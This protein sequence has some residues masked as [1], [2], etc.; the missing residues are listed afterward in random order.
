MGDYGQDLVLVWCQWI[1]LGL[2][3]GFCV[4]VVVD[5][6]FGYG[7]GQVVFVVGDGL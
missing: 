1:G 7:W 6:G 2:L 3:G 4:E 5:Y